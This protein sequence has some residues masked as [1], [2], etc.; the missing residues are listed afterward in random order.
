MINKSF[1]AAKINFKNIKLAY[2]ITAVIIGVVL[3][4]DIVFTVLLRF[5]IELGGEDNMTVGFGNYLYL[6]ILLGAV[7]I[8]TLN[9]RKIMNLGGKRKDFF[10]GC[11]ANYIIM[12]AV[13][14]LAGIILH[15]TYDKYMI[16]FLYRGGTL[17]VLYW[18]GWVDNGPVL[19][20]F[21]QFAFLFLVATVIH[22]L[23]A[24]QDK[25]YGWITDIVIIAIIS[26][27]TPIAP[28]R[29][30]LIWFFYMIIFSNAFVQIASC[31]ILGSAVYA[32]NKIILARKAI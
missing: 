32:L 2:I 13:I 18:F 25:W 22:T 21:Q 6:I 17:N 28:L 24:M 8:P 5:G 3:I 31:L 14:S 29:A 30:A 16:D 9:F 4:Q 15:Y 20:F 27:F 10:W 11:A 7:F 12:A 26:V 23:T 1:T 19:A